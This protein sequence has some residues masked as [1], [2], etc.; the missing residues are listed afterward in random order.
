MLMFWKAPKSIEVGK[1]FSFHDFEDSDL[2]GILILRPKY[3]NVIYYYTNASIEEVGMGA[4]LKFGYQ[5]VKSG[6]H[7]KKDLENS[8]DFVTL[9]GDILSQIIL[10]ETQIES[11]R[12]IYSE[13]SDL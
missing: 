8:E 2:T 9:L 7:I 10:T 3:E 1:D 6:N 4:R 5:I 11:P 13:E 12:K